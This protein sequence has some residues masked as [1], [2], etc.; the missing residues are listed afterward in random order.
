MQNQTITY[1]DLEQKL[2]SSKHSYNMEKIKAAYEYAADMHEGQFRKSGEPYITHPLAVAYIVADLELDTD[3]I[4]AALLHDTIEDCKDK[5]NLDILTKKFGTEVADLVDGLTKLTDIH[6][7]NKETESIENLRKMFLAMS[8]DI[9][10][11]FIK[12]ADRLHNMRTLSAKSESRQR[13]IALETMHVYAPLAH[14]LGIQ[15]IK[16]ELENLALQYLDPIGYDEVR[17]DIEHRYGESKDFLD[18][19]K[20][21][22]S[23]K[24]KEMNIKF[25]IEGRVKSIYSI[26]KKM[27]NQNKSFDEIYDFYAIRIIVDTELECYTVLGIIHEM[28]NLMPGRF[29]DYISTPKPNMYRS[30]HTTVIGRQGIPFEVQ[31][32]TWEMQEVAE[33]GIAA[34]WKYKSGDADKENISEKLKWIK[35]LIENENDAG[36]ADEFLRPLKID[37]FEDETFIF[38]P[39]G[40][41]ISLPYGSNTIDF[42][43]SIH[44]QVGNKMVGA[45]VNGVIVPIDTVLQTGQIC[46]IVTSASSKGPSRDW[47]KIVKTS[48]AK[49]KIRQW[50]KKEK[51]DENIIE[52]KNEIER[53]LKHYG[54]AYTEEQKNE[55][56]ENVAKRSGFNDVDDLYNNIGYGG[57]SVSKISGRLRDEFDRVVR[58]EEDRNAKPIDAVVT[59]DSDPQS[60]LRREKQKASGAMQSVVVDSIDNCQVR[61][62]KCCNPLPGD[63]IIGFVTRGF[64]VSVHKY[65]CPNAVAGLKK[66]DEKDRWVT[67][68][69]SRVSLEQGDNTSGSFE[70]ILRIYANNSMTI[71]AD[72][73]ALFADM[74]VPVHSIN[75]KETSGGGIIINLTI[76]CRNTSHVN[77]IVEKL[78]KLR[79]VIDVT[80]GFS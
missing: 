52:G 2:L 18:N 6:F 73:S 63:S 77:S 49:N 59:T 7:E 79:D 12:L 69:W 24:L 44:S 55:I 25:A 72:I 26:Y 29:K 36:D 27:Y 66:D 31:I 15:R 10:V 51:R 35:T 23:S 75:S 11:I 32:R 50:F 53:E 22:V 74:R 41:V 20:E 57:M 1:Q 62:A 16:T 40:D 54:K 61:F 56:I 39:K 28:Y 9:R 67:V 46:E 8:K 70:A 45:K 30:L 80:R 4:C 43:Y 65:D 33:Y 37:L 17:K 78:K 42:A 3:S 13:S 60:E 48:E 38:T 58:D 5:T 64:G 71:F 21:Q 47:L 68:R 76:T 14:R 19:A 34:H